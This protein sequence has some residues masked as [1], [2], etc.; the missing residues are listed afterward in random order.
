VDALR[1]G[2][3]TTREIPSWR[4]K[5]KGIERSIVIISNQC[6]SFFFVI[7]QD[8]SDQ[9]SKSGVDVQREEKKVIGTGFIYLGS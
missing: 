7:V 3:A 4:S 6:F 5:I 2:A 8:A 1:G 9:L